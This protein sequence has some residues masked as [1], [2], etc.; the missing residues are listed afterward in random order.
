MYVPLSSGSTLLTLSWQR[1]SPMGNIDQRR[2]V[3]GEDPSHRLRR[4]LFPNLLFGGRA[5]RKGDHRL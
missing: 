2:E 5:L 1:H 3:G 4:R